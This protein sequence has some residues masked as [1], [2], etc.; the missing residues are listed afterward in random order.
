MSCLEIAVDSLMLK[1]YS[2][3]FHEPKTGQQIVNRLTLVKGIISI[4]VP[5]AG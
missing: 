3:V 5:I 4:C 1:Y 2:V